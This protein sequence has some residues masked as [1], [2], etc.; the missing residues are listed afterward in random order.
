M[1][2]NVLIKQDYLENGVVKSVILC[3]EKQ[4]EIQNSFIRY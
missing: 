1:N 3:Y 4:A 2:E